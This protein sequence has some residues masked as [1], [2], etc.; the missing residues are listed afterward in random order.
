[1]FVGPTLLSES[2]L[3]PTKSIW[4]S[5]E[6]VITLLIIIVN[7]DREEVALGRFWRKLYGASKALSDHWQFLKSC[8]LSLQTFGFPFL[9]IFHRVINV[10]KWAGKASHLVNSKLGGI[11]SP[12]SLL[13]VPAPPMGQPDLVR[14]RVQ[15]VPVPDSVL[16]RWIVGWPS[17]NGGP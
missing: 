15:Y 11:K 2:Q 5:A 9:G 3:L 7:K 6:W 17:H 13:I 12:R 1:M 4:A 10:W 16:S 14:F 8:L